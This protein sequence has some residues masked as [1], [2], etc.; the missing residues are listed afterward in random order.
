MS[1]IATQI[2]ALGSQG[3]AVAD[4]SEQ[5]GVSADIVELELLRDGQISE[6]DITEEDFRIIRRRL[7]SVAKDSP[8]ENLSSRVGMFLWE[9]KRGSAKLKSAPAL[10]LLQLNAVIQQSSARINEILSG[11]VGGSPVVEIPRRESAESPAAPGPG[12]PI[13]VEP[14]RG[15]S[16]SAPRG[17]DNRSD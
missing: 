3:L 11:S 15:E 5:L 7:I 12:S 1:A 9:Q 17:E 16:D 10:N 2:R 13:S 14:S 4:I 8:D 6:E